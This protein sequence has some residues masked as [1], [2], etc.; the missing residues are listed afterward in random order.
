[1]QSLKTVIFDMDGLIFDTETLYYKANQAAADEM[2]LPFNWEY[3]ERFVG[4]SEYAL[5]KSLTTTFSSEKKARDFIL[6]SEEIALDLMVSEKI[7]KKPGLDSLLP[8]LKESGLDLIIG[9]NSQRKIIELLLNKSEL[10]HFFD[11]YVGVDEVSNGKPAPDIYLRALEKT[12]TKATDALVLEDSINGVKAAHQANIPVIMVPDLEK[13][14]D[15]AKKLAL[16]VHTDL[17]EVHH[18]LR[19]KLKN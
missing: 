5:Y 2:K 8:F 7:E 11:Q 19:K 18:F 6:R 1:M 14:T 13:P 15:E 9:S 10:T 4:S 16:D 3:F 17:H 12:K